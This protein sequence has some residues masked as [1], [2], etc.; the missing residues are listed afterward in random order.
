M[1]IFESLDLLEESSE[2]QLRGGFAVLGG[3][4]I[5]PQNSN[6]DCNCGCYNRDCNCGCNVGCQPTSKPTSNGGSPMGFTFSF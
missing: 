2:G 4:G 5:D 3:D 1:E 6:G